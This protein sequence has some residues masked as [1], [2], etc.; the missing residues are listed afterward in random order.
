[1]SDYGCTKQKCDTRWACQITQ[2][3]DISNTE[4][5][6]NE[7]DQELQDDVEVEPDFPPP[8][9]LHNHS[10]RP[11][12]NSRLARSLTS[13]DIKGKGSGAPKS[14]PLTNDAKEEARLFSLEVL[15]G[16]EELAAQWSMSRCNILILTGLM[17]WE[18]RA[19]NPANKHAEWFAAHHPYQKGGKFPIQYSSYIPLIV[20]FHSQPCGI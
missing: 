14:G 12:S 5:E 15:E 6:G 18:S 2:G 17:I 1:M 11:C 7:E 3:L 16:A 4:D 13:E 19:P 20:M 10:K 8:T 9:Q